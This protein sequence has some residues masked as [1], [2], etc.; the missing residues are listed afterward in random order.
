VNGVTL[1]M[2]CMLQMFVH[3]RKSM[4]MCEVKAS[5]SLFGNII[6][7]VRVK[8]FLLESS[9]LNFVR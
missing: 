4:M 5:V 9:Q 7:Q 3:K 6:V 8:I 1:A 2:H